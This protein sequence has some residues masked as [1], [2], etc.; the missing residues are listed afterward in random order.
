MVGSVNLRPA[1]HKLPSQGVYR[2]IAGLNGLNR[3]T[4]GINSQID[5]INEPIDAMSYQSNAIN[6]PIN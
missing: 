2:S 1:G 5:A 6:Q 3:L 4:D